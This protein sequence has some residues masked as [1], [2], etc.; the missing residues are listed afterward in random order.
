M[1]LPKAVLDVFAF[2]VGEVQAQRQDLAA[3]RAERDALVRQVATLEISNDWMRAQINQL[4]LE[5][6]ELLDKV[7]SIRVPAPQLI[8]E[9]RVT[10]APQGPPAFDLRDFS[11][12]DVGDDIAKKIGLPVYG[13]G[14]N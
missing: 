10:T 6:V 13:D 14:T 9:H 5:R 2:S 12:E 11:F 8:K 3:L 4:Q 7:Y 1:W